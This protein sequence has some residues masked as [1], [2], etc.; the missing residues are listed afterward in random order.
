MYGHVDLSRAWRRSSGSHVGDGSVAYK[1]T[2]ILLTS[3]SQVKCFQSLN[4]L[5][6]RLVCACR[7]KVK[8]VVGPWPSQISR[9]KYSLDLIRRKR[10]RGAKNSLPFPKYDYEPIKPLPCPPFCRN[11][12]F[13][14]VRTGNLFAAFARAISR[15]PISSSSGSMVTV[16]FQHPV[17][18]WQCRN[19]PRPSSHSVLLNTGRPRGEIEP[20]YRTGK[21]I[22]LFEVLRKQI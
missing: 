20:E 7:M 8:L 11:F 21:T 10:S 14:G 18:F 16:S 13:R 9:R 3:P 4:S 2:Q 6:R 19:M 17:F 1:T 15:F 12:P 22:E 5:P